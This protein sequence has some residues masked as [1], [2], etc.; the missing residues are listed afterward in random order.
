MPVAPGSL[1]SYKKHIAVTVST[2]ADGL[3]DVASLGGGVLCSVMMSSDWTDASLTL[4]GSSAANGTFRDVYNS[5]GGEVTIATTANRYLAL[6][7]TLLHGL[8]HVKLRSGPSGAAV[9]Q[10][11]ARTI[12][13]GVNVPG[14]IP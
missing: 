1:P 7:P 9:A 5:T 8:S 13:L 3:S 6:D 10:A 12:T 14:L 11:A 4:L 2:A